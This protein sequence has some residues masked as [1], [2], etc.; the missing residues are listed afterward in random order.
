MDEY[1]LV[2]YLMG[3]NDPAWRIYLNLQ[4]MIKMADQKVYMLLVFSGVMVTIV[5]T[6]LG[7]MNRDWI[8]YAVLLYYLL[9]LIFFILFA[10]QALLA[11]S[12]VKTKESVPQLIFFGHIAKR[13]EAQEYYKDFSRATEED[14]FRDLTYQIYEIG[15]IT[16]KKYFNYRIAWWG[17]LFQFTGF[18]LII[19]ITTFFR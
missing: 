11:R 18:L 5:F 1:D 19:W 7:T 9:A 6:K 14:I 4:N 8:S 13:K 10:L 15:V 2:E 16:R 3:K 12:G 17:I